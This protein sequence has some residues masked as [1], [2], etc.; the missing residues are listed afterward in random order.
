MCEG[1]HDLYTH[2]SLV[3][4][5]ISLLFL[6]LPARLHTCVFSD[7]GRLELSGTPPNLTLGV[8]L[9]NVTTQMTGR[10]WLTVTNRDG[11]YS[12]DFDVGR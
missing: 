11:S 6:T 8:T 2:L 7:A 1:N 3:V 10:W 4:S 9:V 12:V 5:H